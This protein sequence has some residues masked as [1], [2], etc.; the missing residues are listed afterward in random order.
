MNR[1]FLLLACLM[2]LPLRVFAAEAPALVPAAKP[3]ANAEFACLLIVSLDKG[4]YT[5]VRFVENGKTIKE[6]RS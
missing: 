3:D 6:L 5:A 1:H 4:D 2:V